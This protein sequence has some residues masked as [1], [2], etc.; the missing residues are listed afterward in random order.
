MTSGVKID[1]SHLLTDARVRSAQ[2]AGISDR[3]VRKA[4]EAYEDMPAGT[5]RH[6]RMRVAIAAV[7][8]DKTVKPKPTEEDW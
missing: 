6:D 2:A 4:L 3:V 7:M 5:G 1:N 8:R